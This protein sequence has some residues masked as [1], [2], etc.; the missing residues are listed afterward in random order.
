MGAQDCYA[1]S[2][3]LPE[4]ERTRRLRRWELLQRA[5]QVVQVW[6]ATGDLPP[7]KGNSWPTTS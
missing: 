4:D 5:P 6:E 1:Q 2:N 7:L 3:D